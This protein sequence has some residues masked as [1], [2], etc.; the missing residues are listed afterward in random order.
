MYFCIRFQ[1]RNHENFD[2]LTQIQ[3]GEIGEVAELGLL[4]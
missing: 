4:H 3:I 1:D 2:I